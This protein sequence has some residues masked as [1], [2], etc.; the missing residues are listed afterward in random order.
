MWGRG[1]GG[2]GWGR[3]VGVSESDTYRVCRSLDTPT[4]T[5]R[6]EGRA[7]TARGRAPLSALHLRTKGLM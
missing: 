5:I 2:G 7:A 3:S 4:H 1:A 6:C